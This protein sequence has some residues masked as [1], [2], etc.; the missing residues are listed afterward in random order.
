MRY[1]AIGYLGSAYLG[2]NDQSDPGIDYIYNSNT[3]VFLSYASAEA[4]RDKY[5]SPKVSVQD[6][7]PPWRNYYED[8]A[9]LSNTP[10]VIYEL[11]DLTMIS[12]MLQNDVYQYPTWPLYIEDPTKIQV[13][14]RDPEFPDLVHF[15][16]GR[17]IIQM[18]PGRFL[19]RYYPR[20]NKVQVEYYARWWI[21]NK[22]PPRE[23][24]GAVKFA[25]T[26]E[27]IVEVY[28]NGPES[29]MQGMEAVEVYG[30]GDFAIAYMEDAASGEYASRALV[31]Q[32][33]KVFGRIYPDDSDLGPQLESEL[34]ALG[35]ASLEEKGDGFEGAR[36]LKIP[37]DDDDEYFGFKMPYLDRGVVVDPETW[38]ATR[39]PDRY[40]LFSDSTSGVLQ[41]QTSTC[42][43]CGE[44]AMVQ[45]GGHLTNHEDH[46]EMIAFC[47]KHRKE[48]TTFTDEISQQVFA[49][50]PTYID[51][52]G[53]TYSRRTVERLLYKSDY[54]GNWY[55][56]WDAPKVRTYE[57]KVIAAS[58]MQ[59]FGVE[60]NARYRV[61]SSK[62][63]QELREIHEPIYIRE[64]ARNATASAYF[65]GRPYT[66]IDS[67]R[68]VNAR[69]Y[70]DRNDQV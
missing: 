69:S 44:I 62:S 3:R 1:F 22:R 38:T 33:T 5:L 50:T 14:F 16:D 49:G 17:R 65:D 7:L 24:T 70:F 66:E 43:K 58:E 57:N 54:S 59:E 47:P 21:D 39:T 35:Y 26:P 2:Y 48:L 37:T 53:R 52:E 42:A 10:Y 55:F 45:H 34:R 15:H 20:L 30:A 29:C 8:P 25:T 11:N 4:F 19:A 63:E 12:L 23:I 28:A 36:F 9:T 6:G 31:N 27:E 61:Y 18:K 68:I 13:I 64:H 46:D 60:W 56:E 67:R 40:T 32:K 41:I 51:P